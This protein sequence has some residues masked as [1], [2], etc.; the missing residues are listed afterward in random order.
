MCV[1]LLP[2]ERVTRAKARGDRE[3]ARPLRRDDRPRRDRRR[4]RAREPGARRG[5]RR[6]AP[7]RADR[8]PVHG[9]E[10]DR[11]LAR[12]RRGRARR[13]AAGLRRRRARLRRSPRWRATAPAS[14]STST[15]CRCA[16][17]EME[18]WE[19]MISESQ[20]RMVA[21]VRPG[22]ARARSRRSATAGSSTA[23]GDRRG[24]GHGRAARASS[25]ARS[26]ARSRR[27]LLTDE[28][29]RYEVEP[30]R[31]AERRPRAASI[32][33]EPRA[34]SAGS[35]SSTTTSSARAPC[36]G[37]GSTPPCCGCGRRCAGSPSR[38]TGRRSASAT[39]AGR[40]RW[41]CS[42]PRATSPAPAAS[43]SRSPTASTSATRRSPRSPGSSPRR[44]RA[45]PQAAE[46][47]GIP[48][49]SGNVSLYNETDGRA[50]PPTPV[51]GCVGLVPDVREVPRGWRAGDASLARDSLAAGVPTLAS[52]RRRSSALG[53]KRAARLLSLA[54]D[55]ARRRRSPQRARAR[56]ATLVSGLEAD[57]R[58]VPSRGAGHGAIVLACAVG[59]AATLP[60][61]DGL[62]RARDGATDVRRLR[63]PRARPRRRAA[64]L[65]RPLRAPAPR[66]GVG[67]D[68]RLRPAAA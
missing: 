31:A 40:A 3:R 16:R 60:R 7:V 10:A 66:P 50:I 58:G 56:R 8:R 67:R 39:R 19:I 28:C 15:A 42:R 33:V 30:S 62:A 13:V 17:T 64:H 44:S 20:E 24:H 14:T 32:P 5:R 61:R 54:H 53:A 12:A 4:V 2:A 45:S 51:V 21:V 22:A 47:L 36:A 29:P 41:P 25:T 46:A 35:S 68:R 27:A 23:R 63:H 6:E 48:V 55:V 43:R 34:A 26:S 9:Q 49:V 18:P 59:G 65:L 11:G 37:P 57:V 1:G 38:S 52:L